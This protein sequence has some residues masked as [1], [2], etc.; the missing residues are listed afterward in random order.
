MHKL[1]K[2]A[3]AHAAVA[4]LVAAGAAQAQ[5]PGTMM[6]GDLWETF[7]PT[8]VGKTYY[9]VETDPNQLY[10]LFRV[11]NLDRQW[12]TPSQMYPAGENLH[13]PWKQDL[14][15]IEYSPG[16]NN[17]ST[18]SDPR[19]SDYLYAFHTP[20]M[21]AGQADDGARWVDANKRHAQ[22]YEGLTPTNLGIDVKYRVRQ[23]SINHANMNDFLVLEL[24]LTNTGVLDADGD[25]IPEATD[26]RINALVLNLRNELI[27]SM[28]NSRA[29]RRGAAGW[30][31]GPTSGYDASPDA[32][33][34]PWDVPLTFTGP[35]PGKLTKGAG[36]DGVPW[37]DDGSRFLGNTMNRRRNYYD[38]YAGSQW[39]AVKQ[40]T[41]PNGS[42]VNQADKKTIYDSHGVG[43]GAQRGW[44]T[45]SSKGYGNNDHN[46]W[47]DHTLSMGVFY[48]NGGR[49]LDLTALNE[50]PDPNY[51][52]TSH[53]DI[54]KGDPLSFINAVNPEGERGQPRGDMKYN[55]TYDQNWEKN[56]PDP[57]DD[58]TKGYAIAHGFNGD[59]YIGIGP[60]SLE[61]GESMN[62]VL[63]EYGGFRLQGV[64]QARTAA[65]WAYENN[66]VVPEPPPTPDIV[67]APNTN[68]KI[69]IR[70]DD[71]AES[72]ND[73]AGYK[74][75][76]ST[77][78]PQVDS[79]QLGVRMLDRYHEQTEPNPTDAQLAALGVP[80][81][82]NISS[83]AYRSQTP[84]AWGPYHLIANI[85]LSQVSSHL[86]DGADSGTYKY[87]FEDQS[88]LVTFGFTYYYY[89]AAYDNESGTIN[90]VPYTSL[91]THRVNFNGRTGLWEGT[92]WWTTA[93][94]FF[95][96]PNDLN[97][98]KDIGAPFILKAP[99]AAAQDLKDG[100][101]KIQVLP[102]PY[103]RQA[104][105]DIL[106]EHKVLFINLPTGTKITILDVSGQT[107][108]VLR[109]DGTNQFDGTLFWDMF[110]KDGIE[111]TSGLYI[112]V[113]EYP[114]GKQTGHFAILQ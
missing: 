39:I 22:I 2:T 18:S 89:V 62:V 45:S 54:V 56:N 86:N 77:P 3:G 43:E 69:D 95:P 19:A 29:G 15:M 10:H 93:N 102:N 32:N 44:Y 37:A 38:I 106:V 21:S 47:T 11:G 49:I 9:E 81:N 48:E 99:L 30:F 70:W 114:G 83:T 20:N 96:D 101:L 53:P 92:Y 36:P 61:V 41:L 14:E 100:I 27:N 72:A 76:R 84:G 5:G 73:F 35:P 90:G 105:H 50:L 7:L 60:F 28:S 108:D 52:D 67:V 112:Y 78:F 110:S 31:T 82:P 4:V 26:N 8:N 13:L 33:G 17:F 55:G 34:N 71:R 113:A 75:Y 80:N 87:A 58:W 98:L 68:L 103:K 85:P 24:Q 109:F 107:I 6:A 104:L 88:D 46:P 91:E 12:T 65:Q 79:Q 63:A 40:G 59:A 16:I 23:W 1:L 64:R 74:I 42:S 51:F 94:S 57:A 97:A 111:V 66:W 25:G